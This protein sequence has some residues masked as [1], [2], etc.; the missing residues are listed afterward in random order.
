VKLV[1][2]VL[3]SINQ[4]N[5][6]N[7]RFTIDKFNKIDFSTLEK[8]LTKFAN[9][10]VSLD[11]KFLGKADA[12]EVESNDLVKSIGILNNVVDDIKISNMALGSI[13]GEYIESLNQ[14][15]LP[16]RIVWQ[17]K[18]GKENSKLLFVSYWM[19]NKNKWITRSR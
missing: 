5:K 9:T 15:K 10:K 4:N 17:F 8:L 12:I 6:I 18:D 13:E 3:K 7:E 1:D 19:F 11:T 14:Y 16:L 2:E